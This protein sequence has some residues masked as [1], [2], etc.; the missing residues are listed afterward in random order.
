MT[1]AMPGASKRRS[2]FR[3]RV[4]DNV[5]GLSL[6]TG[7]ALL[8]LVMFG[9]ARVWDSGWWALLIAAVFVLGPGLL[10]W[11][12]IFTATLSLDDTHVGVERFF[13]RRRVPRDQVRRVIGLPGRILF[14]GQANRVLLSVAR[15]WTD[16][17][18]RAIAAELGLKAEGGARYFGRM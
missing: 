10:P 14:V 12:Y 2:E 17:Q 7:V 8:F 15:F 13:M 16:D 5:Y 9:V 18:V 4:R 1:D 11:I 6:L 3:P